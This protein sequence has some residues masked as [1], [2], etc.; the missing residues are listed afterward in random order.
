M[1]KTLSAVLFTLLCGLALTGCSHDLEIKNINTYRTSSF[2]T[3]TDPMIVGI[4]ATTA[5]FEEEKLVDHFAQAMRKEGAQVLYPYNPA[6]GRA[7]V[8]A[9]V[10]LR[11]DYK[12][13][14]ANF[15][16]TWPGFLIWT[17]AW[18]GFVYK[19]DYEFDVTLRDEESKQMIGNVRERVH[20]NI[21]HAEMDRTWTEIGWLEVGLIP[22]VGGFF[23]TQYDD[24]I[25]PDV[26]GLGGP[27]AGAYVAR[28]VANQIGQ[29]QLMKD[30]K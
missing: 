7:A 26:V 24:D 28:R 19:H 30:S 25:T 6:S 3:I 29:W 10:D 15:F 8:A 2:G 22:F 23:F 9:M 20:Y 4:T 11:T 1:P 16:I 13:S 27:V 17:P 5:S 18:N 14:W 21:R 12:G